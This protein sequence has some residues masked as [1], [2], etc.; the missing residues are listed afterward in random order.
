[1]EKGGSELPLF[2]AKESSELWSSKRQKTLQLGEKASAKL[3][4]PIML[5]F[6][7]II[8]IIMAAAFAGSL[9]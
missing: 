7:G 4:A 9:F 5:V 3:L 6:I 2:L 1:M 8:I